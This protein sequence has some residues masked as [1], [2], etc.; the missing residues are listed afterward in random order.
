VFG[1]VGIFS[2]PPERVDDDVAQKAREQT[3]RTLQT[4]P[5]FAGL[6]VLAK[7]CTALAMDWR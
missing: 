4:I 3:L 2:G 5:G 6:H 1:R 7:Y